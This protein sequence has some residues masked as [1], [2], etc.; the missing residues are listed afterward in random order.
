MVR[1]TVSL[2]EGLVEAL[3]AEGVLSRYGSFSE[4]VSDALKERLKEHRLLRYKE[5]MEAMAEDP[6]VLEDIAEIEEAFA[7]ADR[8]TG[9][10]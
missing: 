5:A 1:K 4:M 9:A 6:M 7:F 8:E 2:E 3:E 10:V